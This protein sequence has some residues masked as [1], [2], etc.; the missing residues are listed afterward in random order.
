MAALKWAGYDGLIIQGKSDKPVYLSLHNGK[1]ELKDSA[2]LWGK[3]TRETE[4]TLHR[5]SGN[6]KASI[7]DTR[8]SGEHLLSGALLISDYNHAT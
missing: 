4:E 7:I 5:E 1:P 6:T 2:H 3:D 8:P